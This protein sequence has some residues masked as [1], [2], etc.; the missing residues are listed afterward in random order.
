MKAKLLLPILALVFSAGVKGGS[1]AS[2]QLNP[3]FKVAILETGEFHGDE[4]TATSG[5]TWLGLHVSDQGSRLLPYRLKVEAVHDPI[6]DDDETQQTGKALS[7]DVPVQPA[8]LLKGA[9]MLS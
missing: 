4:V 3:K 1:G 7:V 5:E 9:S 8:F 6:L 2:Q